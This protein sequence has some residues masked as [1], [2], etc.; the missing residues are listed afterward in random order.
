M[1][2]WW[3]IVDALLGI[4]DG[5]A[6]DRIERSLFGLLLPLVP[7]LYGLSS[8]ISGQSVFVGGGRLTGMLRV[9]HL[10]GTSAVFAGVFYITV[11][12]LMHV[13]FVWQE[14]P[15]LGQLFD[16]ARGSLLIVLIVSLLSMFWLILL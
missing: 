2:R 16:L 13:H 10:S 4:E 6:E 9:A 12:L 5:S 11:A 3:Q 7:L 15:R 14:H 1:E 8:I